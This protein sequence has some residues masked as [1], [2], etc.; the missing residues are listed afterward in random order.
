MAKDIKI[1]KKFRILNIKTKKE[2]L[3]YTGFVDCDEPVYTT[4]FQEIKF[5]AD[6]IICFENFCEEF[7]KKEV[8]KK[9]DK[10]FWAFEEFF[11]FEYGYMRVRNENK[12]I[13]ALVK[14]DA[15]AKISYYN[16]DVFKLYDSDY[17]I[18]KYIRDHEAYTGL[19]S[20][21]RDVIDFK[22]SEIPD[23]EFEFYVREALTLE[24]KDSE[25]LQKVAAIKIKLKDGR[26]INGYETG[27]FVDKDMLEE[28]FRDLIER[29]D[30]MFTKGTEELMTR[31]VLVKKFGGYV[32]R[33]FADHLIFITHVYTPCGETLYRT[34]VKKGVTKKL[35][36]KKAYLQNVGRF[37]GKG[38]ANIKKISDEIGAFVKVID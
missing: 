9:F 18:F 37:I 19:V 21:W 15:I 4:Y 36:V 26:E 32:V 6:D 24:L 7:K 10:D 33:E 25:V 1:N 16:Q 22:K 11:R 31:E 20:K 28:K 17:N 13:I 23:K 12:K 29:V 35:V 34:K 27:T 14:K 30:G 5:E 38:G 2:K 3:G 8:E